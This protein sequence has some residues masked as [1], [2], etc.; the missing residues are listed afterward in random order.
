MEKCISILGSTG[1][2]GVQTLGVV[3]NLGI[4]VQGLTAD[5]NIDLLEKQAREFKP[6]AVSISCNKQAEELRSRLGGLNI[7]V[8]SG[9]EGL[10]RIATLEGVDTVVNSLVGIAGLMPTMEAIRNKKGIALANKETLVAAGSLVMA[11]AKKHSVEIIPIDSEHS[12][13]FQCIMGNNKANVSKLILTA[14]GGPFRGCRYEDL[15]HI[16]PEEALKHPNWQMGN[17]ITIDSATL[18][19]KGL[20]V[21]EARW[22]FDINE[23]NIKV[24]IHP[25]SI[26]HSMV[27]YIDG[28]V[29]AQLG[30][31]DMR[32]PI[33]F[34]LTYPE[35]SCNN[36]P[37]LNLAEKRT[38]T[39]EEPDYKVF[40]C[41]NL[42]YE[43]LKAS[44]TMPAAMSGAN[45]MAVWLFLNKKIKFTHIPE[46]IEKVMEKH[47][48]NNN[49]SINDIIEV[50]TWAKEEAA[51]ICGK[52][53]LLI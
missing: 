7:E 33:Q 8:Y 41:L 23:D 13:I 1:S 49:P 28:S 36:F 6:K 51:E 38:L 5:K 2:I 20:E 29:I 43:A 17:K 11:E 22:L 44:G 39:F 35:R 3:R 32:I 19:N 30:P 12:A 9:A 21:I 25:Q 26:I 40:P 53:E 4:R 45:E 24:L 27:E 16:T 10:I 47:K 50:D 42:A 15:I 31:P 14:S 37:K 46:L 18:M 34:A 52:G 48:V